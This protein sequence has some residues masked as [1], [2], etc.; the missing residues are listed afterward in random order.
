MALINCTKSKYHGP[1]DSNKDSSC[2]WCEPAKPSVKIIS[3]PASGK[4]PLS[5]RDEKEL[6]IEKICFAVEKILETKQF[7]DALISLQKHDDLFKTVF[8]KSLD[9][10]FEKDYNNK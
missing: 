7:S 6:T 2:P 4:K 9:D 8:G 3:P 10:E 5:S 1:Y